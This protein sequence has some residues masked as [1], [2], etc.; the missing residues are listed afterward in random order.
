MQAE[1]LE[2]L[3]RASETLGTGRERER[4][5]SSHHFLITPGSECGTLSIPC[6]RDMSLPPRGRFLARVVGRLPAEAGGMAKDDVA[7]PS[8]RGIRCPAP[9]QAVAEQFIRVGLMVLDGDRHHRAQ[10]ARAEDD[11]QTR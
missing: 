8:R 4:R 2:A 9:G 3:I 11:V 6:R 7:V 1:D 10:S 5:E